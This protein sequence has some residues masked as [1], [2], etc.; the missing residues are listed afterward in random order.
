MTLHILKKQ[1]TF[2]T[3]F[4]ISSS[5]KKYKAE[6]STYQRHQSYKAYQAQ[7]NNKNIVFLIYQQINKS[8]TKNLKVKTCRNLSTTENKLSINK[9]QN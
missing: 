3:M 7:I 4:L 2:L 8:K 1:L 5:Y 9:N 6:T